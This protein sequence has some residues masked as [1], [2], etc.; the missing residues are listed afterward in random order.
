MPIRGVE[1]WDET[2]TGMDREGD[3]GGGVVI[4]DSK[5]GEGYQRIERE[6]KMNITDFFNRVWCSDNIAGRTL[7]NYNKHL[8]V[9]IYAFMA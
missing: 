2:S 6:N 1:G 9:S 3:G 5:W 4:K 8:T 7:L